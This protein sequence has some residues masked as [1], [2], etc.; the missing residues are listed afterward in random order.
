MYLLIYDRNVWSDDFD[1]YESIETI[2][3]CKSLEEAERLANSI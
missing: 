1:D 2:E 3:I